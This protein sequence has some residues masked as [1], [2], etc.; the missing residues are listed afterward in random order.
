MGLISR[1]GTAVIAGRNRRSCT[2]AFLFRLA[3]PEE[4]P[5]ALEV[6]GTGLETVIR[7]A[8][9]VEEPKGRAGWECLRSGIRSLRFCW[10][11]RSEQNAWLGAIVLET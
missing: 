7:A 1:P 10:P 4:L 2:L 6:S 5:T 9:V 3:V 8:L 11:W